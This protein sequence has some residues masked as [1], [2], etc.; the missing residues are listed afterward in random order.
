MCGFVAAA[1]FACVVATS[2]V[3]SG[4]RTVAISGKAARAPVIGAAKTRFDFAVSGRFAGFT[5]STWDEFLI[6]DGS[7]FP[8]RVVAPGSSAR[9]ETWIRAVGGLDNSTTPPTLISTAAGVTILPWRPIGTLGRSVMI[10]AA[11]AYYQNRSDESIVD[12]LKLNNYQDIRFVCTSESGIRGS[13]VRALARA[14]MRVWMLT[15]VRGTYS[16]AD[17]PTGWEVWQMRLRRPYSGMGYVFFCPNDPSFREWKKRQLADALVAHPFYGV[18]LC[19]IYLPEYPGP[20]SEHYGCLCDRC[21]AAFVSMYPE[22]PGLPDFENPSS[23]HYWRNDT[24]LYRKWMDFRVAT[25]NGYL[26]DLTNSPDGIRAKCPGVRV[27][28][29]TLGLD[30]PDQI[31][32]VR[33]YYGLD[34]AAMVRELEPDLHAIQTDWPDWVKSS[35]PAD[36]PL[37]YQPIVDSIRAVSPVIPVIMTTD[38]GSHQDVRRTRYW[39]T[40]AERYARIA[41]FQSTAHYEHHLGAYI[42]TEP[43]YPLRAIWENGKVRISFQKCVDPVSAANTANYVL[44]SG[45]V[46]SAAPDGSIVRLS[47]AGV[48]LPARVVV[49]GIRDDELRRWFHDLPA[50][51]MQSNVELSIQ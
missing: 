50:C 36:Y 23:P 7:G 5:G 51:T 3:G 12:E 49:S 29:W 22:V 10:D 26:H 6:D 38:I 40:Q 11:M 33:E 28:T 2:A 47:V 32:K 25:V 1:F 14:G 39:I 13:L 17:L 43:P 35:L 44:S 37:R 24:E 15:F 30:V 31:A 20:T 27:A 21:A 18:D 8:V 4:L 46:T 41:G 48:S 19:E 16:T 42:Y 34:A 45:Q 9:S